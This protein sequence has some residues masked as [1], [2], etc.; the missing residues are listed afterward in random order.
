MQPGTVLQMHSMRCIHISAACINFNW[1]LGGMCQCICEQN[2]VIF[3]DISA[4]GFVPP[5]FK[6]IALFLNNISTKYTFIEHQD[7]KK[8]D[9]KYDGYRNIQLAAFI[10][11]S[12]HHRTFRISGIWLICYGS[13]IRSLKLVCSTNI[14]FCCFLFVLMNSANKCLQAI[15]VEYPAS[16]LFASDVF[17]GTHLRYAL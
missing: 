3:P 16:A 8:R 10:S 12:L 9:N 6:V 7:K 11:C 4:V 2:H 1:K 14:Y 15:H 13:P 5:F 17:I